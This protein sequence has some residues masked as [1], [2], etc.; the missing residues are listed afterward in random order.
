MSD[1]N[2]FSFPGES[3]GQ[4][5]EDLFGGAAF[6][7][8]GSVEDVENPFANMAPAT[9]PAPP[10]PPAPAAPVTPPQPVRQAPVQTV[11]QQPPVQPA[12]QRAEP[13]ASPVSKEK[14]KTPP[15]QDAEEP[16]PLLAAMDLY[17]G[18]DDDLQHPGD[19]QQHGAAS[20]LLH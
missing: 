10:A 20:H 17:G 11:P 3:T 13:P 16:N 8:L 6:T 19:R 14:S 1:N 2:L 9:P 7:D 5:G 4:T 12:H 15:A 18:G